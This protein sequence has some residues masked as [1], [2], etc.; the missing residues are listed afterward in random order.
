MC[1][2]I[3]LHYW[4]LLSCIASRLSPC[5]QKEA[6]WCWNR[7]TSVSSRQCSSSS[8]TGNH[9]NNRLLGF[10]RLDHSPYS[11]DLAP[12][13]F[14]IFPKLKGDLRGVKRAVQKALGTLSEDWFS[15]MY[16]KWVRR[17][18]MRHGEWWILQ[19]KLRKKNVSVMTLF[20]SKW[21][22][23]T[24]VYD[25]YV[26]LNMFCVCQLC[27]SLSVIC[28]YILGND[29]KKSATFYDFVQTLVTNCLTTPR[30]FR[31]SSIRYTSCGVNSFINAKQVYGDL[32]L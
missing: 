32:F 26:F 24:M 21:P 11:P 14:A 2:A 30:T 16:V 22:A 9:H 8:C 28:K 12:V 10:Q 15:Q 25:L 18:E 20:Q 19:G 29:N 1:I 31:K 13:D 6:P 17:H 7:I 5:D 4:L 3:L 27:K 23:R